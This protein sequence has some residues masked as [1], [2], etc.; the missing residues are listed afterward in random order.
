MQM[1][2]FQEDPVI[3]ENYDGALGMPDVPFQIRSEPPTEEDLNKFCAIYDTVD[4]K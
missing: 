3:P 1:E 2:V 4:R